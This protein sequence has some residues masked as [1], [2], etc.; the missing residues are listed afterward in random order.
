MKTTISE[1]KKY[2]GKEVS[3]DGWVYNIRSI[4]KIWFLILRD[5][6]GLVQCVVVDKET[7]KTTFELE[8]TL[9]QESSVTIDGIVRSEPRSVGGY[10]LGVT[11]ITIHQIADEYPISHKEHGADFLMSNRHLWLRSKNQNAILKIR[12]QAIKATRDFF[13]DNGFVLMDSPI[14]TANSVEGTSTLFELDY[15]DRSAYLTQS[16]QL[17]GEASAMAFGKIYVFGPTF[18]AEKSKTRRHLTEFW[19]VEPEMAYCDLNENMDWAEKHVSYVVQW[20]LEHC[21]EELKILER[22]TSK[23]EK[24]IP[25][26]PRITY[27]EAVNILKKQD[28]DFK[29]GSDFGGADETVISEEFDR[30]VMIHRWPSEIKAFYMKRDPENDKLALGVDMIAPEGFGE[31]VGGGQR[32][33]D[34]DILLSRIKE[35]KLPVEPFQ[36]YLDLRKYGSVPHSGYGLGIERTVGWICGTKHVRETIPYPR[37]IYRIEP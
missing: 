16:G 10:E 25:P 31:I 20:C 9:T 24:T 19:M 14:L 27:D 8:N 36:W 37:T 4:G 2:D 26:F 23:L 28:I 15:F 12:H 34:H 33:D 22:D 13:D 17:Y 18:R 5:G 3:L 7:D 21:Q 6:T 30:P 11:N 29:Y 35:H 1:L 32:E